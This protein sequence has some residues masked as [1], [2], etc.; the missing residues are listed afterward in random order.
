MT[1]KRFLLSIDQ[2]TT[3]TRSI[4]FGFD[5]SIVATAQKPLQ[6]QYPNDGWVEHDAVEIWTAT[7]ET[8]RGA[9]K[10]RDVSE[11]AG[12]GITNQRETTVLW[13]RKTGAPLHHAIVWQDRRTA[14]LC[15]KLKSEGHETGVAKKTGLLLDP[16][17]S[18]TKLKWLLDNVP[19]ARKRA[20]R[21]ELAF[22]TIDSWLIFKLTGGRV[23]A[24]DAT[25]ASRTL[26][27]NIHTQD[28]DTD[29]LRILDIPR[30]L[31]PKV[32]DSTG[33]VAETDRGLFGA[34]LPISGVAGDQQAAAFGQAC[35]DQGLMKSTY[36]TGCFALTNTGRTAVSSRNKLIGTVAYRLSGQTH[37]A[38]EGSIFMAGATIQWLRDGLK[39][40]P[41]AADSAALSQKAD[42]K[43]KVVM[44]PA[45]VG[46]GAPYWDPNARGAILG[47]TR[48]TGPA[49]IAKAGL[50][51]VCFQTRDLMEAMAAD[52]KAMGL[53][54]PSALRVDGGMVTNDVFCQYLAD[55]TGR[56]IDRPQIVE[57]TALGAA[58]LA[59][60]GVG[61]YKSEQELAKNWRL[62]RR[63]EPQLS[64]AARDARYG[65]WKDA[66]SRVL[67]KG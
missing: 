42:P 20:A 67:S 17:F 6:Q 23:H 58:Y 8:V 57:T 61:V 1:A 27:F 52:M 51:A 29:I 56:P 12:I 10:G 62:D 45:F 48:D 41:N 46:L 15:A 13:D 38:L 66:V 32:T 7:L 26:L 22:G 35:Y 28:W 18:G 33:V 3:S 34:P 25:N 53:S 9:L 55:L 60:L 40:F 43:S 4:L 59:G 37:Y 39:L 36:G 64:P 54:A 65:D 49:E 44:V 63:F 14:D 19:D 21:G 2:G 24:T 31:L 5:A 11:I 30:E 16:Y 50:E 47:M